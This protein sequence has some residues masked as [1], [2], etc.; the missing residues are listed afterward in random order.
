MTRSDCR[1]LVSLKGIRRIYTCGLSGIYG[2]WV[3][4]LSKVMRRQKS[5]H[6]YVC[7]DFSMADV[8]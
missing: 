1:A 5:T 8:A 4:Y 6:D 2:V 3:G 7:I